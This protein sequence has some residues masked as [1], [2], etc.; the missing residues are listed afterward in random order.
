MFVKEL[1]EGLS[2]LLATCIW[3][4]NSPLVHFG[5]LVWSTGLAPDPLVESITEAKDAKTGR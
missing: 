1:G 2:L 3:V 5:L 4:L